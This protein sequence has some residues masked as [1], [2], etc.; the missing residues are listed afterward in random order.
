LAPEKN[1]PF[2]AR[3]VCRFLRSRSDARFLVVGEGPS[4]DDIRRA[5]AECD[6]EDRLHHPGAAL[7]GQ[8]LAD[9]YHAM[10]VFAFA[11][12]SETQGMVLAEAMT[13]GVPVVAVDAAGVR[14]VVHDGINGRLLPGDQDEPFAAALAW[15]AERPAQ[16]YR[17]LVEQALQTATEFSMA[18]C[19]AR[20]LSVY[21]RVAEESR[22]KKPRDDSEWAGIVRFLEEEWKIISGMASA[23]GDA[24]RGEDPRK[25][26][27]G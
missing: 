23:V 24:L 26:D 15:C 21:R 16:D 6:V 11:S 27:L 3:A 19:A 14:E 1:L 5:C 22:G 25:E 2:L 18:K 12:H 20:L 9:A 17:S 10:D 13:A 8:D 4:L 7:D